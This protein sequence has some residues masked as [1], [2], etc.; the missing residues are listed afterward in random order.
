MVRS[1]RGGK[2]GNKFQVCC[3][4]RRFDSFEYILC[5]ILNSKLVQTGLT[6]RIGPQGRDHS[7]TP[8]HTGGH[9]TVVSIWCPTGDQGKDMPNARI[10]MVVGSRAREPATTTTPSHHLRV[11]RVTQMVYFRPRK[12]KLSQCWRCCWRFARK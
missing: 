11:G 4:W 5:S 12:R 1:L 2:Q 8:T 3:K 7:S 6:L 9:H 10:C